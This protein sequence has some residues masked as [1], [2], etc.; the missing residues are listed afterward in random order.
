[1][2]LHEKKVKTSRPTSFSLVFVTSEPN[3]DD[4]MSL[5]HAVRQI[6]WGVVPRLILTRL[7]VNTRLKSSDGSIVSPLY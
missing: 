2:L 1:M 4:Y 3:R 6:A 7:S 5:N